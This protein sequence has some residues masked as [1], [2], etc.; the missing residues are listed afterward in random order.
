VLYRETEGELIRMEEETFRFRPKQSAEGEESYVLESERLYL[1]TG[2]YRLKVNLE[3]QLHWETFFLGSRRLQKQHLDTSAGRRL[4]IQLEQTPPLPLEVRYKVSDIRSGEDLTKT[5]GFF[6]F[7]NNRKIRWSRRIAATLTTGTI[8]SFM[9]DHRGYHPQKF[10]LL[11]KPYQ[12]LLQLDAQLIPYPGTLVI[13]SDADGLKVLLD[14]SPFYLSG[15]TERTYGSLEPLEA[16]SRELVLDPGEYLL[17]V[18]ND[19]QL[20]RS[21]P[22]TVVSGQTARVTVR[23]DKAE[24]TL[25]VTGK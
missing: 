5:A 3:G 6:I 15:G 24:K 25:E 20:S 16:G 10:D 21:I 17:T 1:E 12:P 23:Y 8:Y 4:Q 2:R 11:I 14:D 13:D 22:V 18:K 19:D 9:I 7:L